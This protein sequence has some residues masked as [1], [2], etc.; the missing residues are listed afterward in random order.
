MRPS[1]PLSPDRLTPDQRLDEVAELVASALVRLRDRNAAPAQVADPD[2][3]VC[4]AITGDES[5]HRDPQ[6]AEKSLHKETR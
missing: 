6:T 1:H 3:A 2:D 4:L 5:V